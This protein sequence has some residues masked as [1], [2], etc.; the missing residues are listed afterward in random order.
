MTTN[1]YSFPPYMVRNENSYEGIFP[2]I[3]NKVASTCCKPCLNGHGPTTVDYE[4]DKEHMAAEKHNVSLVHKNEYEAD[5]SFPVEGHKGQSRY[6]VYRYVPLM[7]SAGVAL[8]APLPS[9]EEKAH[10]VIHVGVACFPML[11]LAVL[12]VLL[13]GA[14]L[15]A[16]VSVTCKR[17]LNICNRPPL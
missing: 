1:W 16:L 11:L 10:F 2:F 13:A 6:G 7:E 12:M 14:I 3:L 4:H 9:A 8:V 15:W 5:M 17:K